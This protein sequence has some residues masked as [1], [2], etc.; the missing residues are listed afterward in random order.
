MEQQL[1][2]LQKQI[3]DAFI[4]QVTPRRGDKLA[5]DDDLFTG[6]IWIGEKAVEVGLADGIGH[7]VPKMKELFGDKTRFSVHGK[8]KSFLRRFSTSITSEAL[9]AVEDRALWA[10]FGL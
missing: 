1:K 3:H 9:N 10:Q 6:E 2:A 7:V 8:K 4:S 5:T